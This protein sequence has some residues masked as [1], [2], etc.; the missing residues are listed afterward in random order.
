[1]TPPPSQPAALPADHALPALRLGAQALEWRAWGNEWAD[2]S[3]DHI[4]NLT[5]CN[6]EDLVR[7]V[8]Q[9]IPQLSPYQGGAEVFRSTY[10]E[11]FSHRPPMP[12]DADHKAYL[13]LWAHHGGHIHLCACGAAVGTPMENAEFS[14]SYA[15]DFSL[16]VELNRLFAVDEL[17]RATVA[18]LN[19]R[20]NIPIQ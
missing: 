13:V 16:N 19:L 12:E 7:F 2:I 17:L 1:M 6:L 14:N 20:G 11:H 10:G 4:P 9:F 8:Q 15:F 3:R 18:W 5:P